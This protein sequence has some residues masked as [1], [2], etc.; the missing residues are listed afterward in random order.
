MSFIW[1]RYQSGPCFS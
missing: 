1:Q